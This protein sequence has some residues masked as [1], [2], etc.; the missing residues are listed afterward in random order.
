MWRN[1]RANGW[2]VYHKTTASIEHSNDGSTGE[3]HGP[4][5]MEGMFRGDK[6]NGFGR[7]R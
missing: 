7:L 4:I 5:I 6:L 3:S 1:D 2:G